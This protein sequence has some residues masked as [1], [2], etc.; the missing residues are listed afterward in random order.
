MDT[1][2]YAVALNNTL[3]ELRSICLDINT[4]FIF[5]KDGVVVAADEA[6]TEATM[7]KTMISLQ[8]IQDKAASLGGLNMLLIDGANGKL[9]ISTVNDL[10]LA[11]AAAKTADLHHIASVARVIVPTI[12]KILEGL[13]PTPLDLAPSQELIVDTL[14][15]FFV[16]STVEIDPQVLG[17]W[18]ELLDRKEIDEVEIE[19]FSG[20][21]TQCKAKE[22]GDEKLKG[23][24]IIRIPEKACKALHV[25]KGELVKVRPTTD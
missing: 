14:T 17:Q 16:G 6:A 5:T 25:K 21:K 8:G 19:A 15:G 22:I 18:S 10:Y 24:G 23:K 13:A 1:D 4:S 11:T 3:N 12:L 7:Q 9:A 2:V 20:K